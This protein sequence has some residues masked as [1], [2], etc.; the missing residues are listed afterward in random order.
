MGDV[1][2]HADGNDNP[3]VLLRGLHR[4]RMAFFGL[5]I[6]LA[7]ITLGAAGTLLL[8]RPA[9]RQPPVDLEMA[10]NV[11]LGRFRAELGLTREQADQIQQ[12]LR[13]R[14][15]KLREIR[16]QARPQIEEQLGAVKEE[17]GAVLTAEQRERW[18]G[19]MLRL[20]REFRRGMRRGP[21]GPGPGFRGGRDRSGPP[22]GPGRRFNDRRPWRRGPGGQPLV[23]PV[24]EP[25]MRQQ[26]PN[27]VEPGAGDVLLMV[28]PR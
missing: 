3:M 25:P 11:M 24:N 12:I 4:W 7:G 26:G 8:V 28:R 2:N 15:Q 13:S 22:G 17:I 10:T 9:E 5:V 16:L 14:M 20:E 23:P 19:I 21:G 1:M 6:L 18:Q 27:D